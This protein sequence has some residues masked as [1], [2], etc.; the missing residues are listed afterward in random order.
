VPVEAVVADVGLAADEPLDRNVALEVI[1]ADFAPALLPVEAVG[2]FA[3]ESV[4]VVDGLVVHALVLVHRLD[5]R[6]G[7]EFGRRF[8]YVWHFA[9][10]DPAPCVL[11]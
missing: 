7:H 3:P 2:D 9:L 11:T 10:L 5:V 6:F 4:H 1:L 8:E